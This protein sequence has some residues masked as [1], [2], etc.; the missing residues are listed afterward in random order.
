VC[1]SACVSA[2]VDACV[3][4]GS[5]YEGIRVQLPKAIILS[6]AYNSAI[7]HYTHNTNIISSRRSVIFDVV[8]LYFE[9]SLKDIVLV[10][11]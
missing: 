6:L 5:I 4:R 2:F 9:D 7:D 8:D 1:V 10:R 11:I 3:L